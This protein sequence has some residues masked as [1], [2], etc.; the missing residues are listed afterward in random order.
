MPAAA[1]CR[2]LCRSQAPHITP[3]YH[4]RTWHRADLGADCGVTVWVYGGPRAAA[5]IEAKDIEHADRES[6]RARETES[7]EER[8]ERER[9][10][11]QI[12]NSSN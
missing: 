5:R 10:R 2:A 8:D 1:V 6:E 7:R 9:V 12:R 3:G 11:E 4:A